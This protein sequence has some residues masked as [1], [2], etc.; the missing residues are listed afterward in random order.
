MADR[1][2]VIAFAAA[3]DGIGANPEDPDKRDRYTSLIAP[4]ETPEQTANMAHLW[5]CGLVNR[6]I[7]YEFIQHPRLENPYRDQMALTDLVEIG[8]QANASKPTTDTPEPGDILIVGGGPEHGGPWHTY[9]CLPD[10]TG[11][12]GGQKDEDGYQIIRIRQHSTAGGWDTAQDDQSGKGRIRRRIR[13]LFDL[14]A[15]LDRFGR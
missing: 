13:H 14:S 4:H 10:G 5:G 6:G 1:I 15:I 3:L 8:E 7:L 2:T 9:I 12:D 11:L